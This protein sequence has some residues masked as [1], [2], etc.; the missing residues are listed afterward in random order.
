MNTHER[1]GLEAAA[2][3]LFALPFL[4]AVTLVAAPADHE[5][6]VIVPS[7]KGLVFVASAK[8]FQKSGISL[9]GVSCAGVT[10]AQPGFFSRTGVRLHRPAP[11]V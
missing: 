6:V 3:K 2:M 1:T 10:H 8:D 11:D 4:F 9:A 5:N 7:L